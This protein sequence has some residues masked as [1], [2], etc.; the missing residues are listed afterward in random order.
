MP[1]PMSSPN[2]DKSL[3]NAN[4]RETLRKKNQLK[5]GKTSKRRREDN[6]SD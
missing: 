4:I 5:T 3:Q 1:G 6:A 2:G